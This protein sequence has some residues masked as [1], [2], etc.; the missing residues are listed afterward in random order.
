MD[1]GKR[2]RLIKTTPVIQLRR[3]KSEMEFLMPFLLSY[4]EPARECY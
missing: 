2:T 3:V 1:A 4:H